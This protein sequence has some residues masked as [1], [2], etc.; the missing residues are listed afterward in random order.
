MKKIFILSLAFSLIF[1]SLGFAVE[2]SLEEKSSQLA[3]IIESIKNLINSL[4]NEQVAAVGGAG[5]TFTEKVNAELEVLV[6]GPGK[7][8]FYIYENN[9]NSLGG[10]FKPNANSWTSKLDF[11]GV[12]T[13]QSEWGDAR[14][15]GTLIAPQFMMQ[16]KHF[17]LAVGFK[18]RFADKNGVTVEREVVDFRDIP[19]SDIRITKLNLPLRPDRFK[20]YKVFDHDDFIAKT[21]FD[22]IPL[23]GE[24]PEGLS[25]NLRYLTV[26][27][28]RAVI[29][30]QAQKE[31]I[32]S[33]GLWQSMTA[34]CP[35]VMAPYVNRNFPHVRTYDSGGPSF[36]VYNNELVFVGT[37][38]TAM[39]CS[40]GAFVSNFINQINDAM[41]SMGGSKSIEKISLSSFPNI[42]H[43][44]EF[45]NVGDFSE[46][47]DLDENI[48]TGKVVAKLSAYDRDLGQSIK[49]IEGVGNGNDFF[50]V[51]P[52][53]EVV[54]KDGTKFDF[55]SK[56][57]RRAGG[58]PDNDLTSSPMFNLNVIVEDNGN[59]VR[60]HRLQ[61]ST[62]ANPTGL[63]FRVNNIDDGE[64]YNTKEAT[65]SLRLVSVNT[66]QIVG[67]VPFEISYEVKDWGVDRSFNVFLVKYD[68]S[69]NYV[70]AVKLGEIPIDQLTESKTAMVTVSKALTANRAVLGEG[71][72]YKIAI[73]AFGLPGT[74]KERLTDKASENLVSE[75]EGFLNLSLTPISVDGITPGEA[76]SSIQRSI[77]VITP[78][79]GSVLIPGRKIKVEWT[80][81]NIETTE[82]L[83]IRLRSVETGQEYNLLSDVLNDETE[84]VTVLN[85]IPIGFYTLEV[86]STQ[87]VIGSSEI[88]KV[89]R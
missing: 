32:T 56:V 9:A 62:G 39:F 44:P 57:F 24:N 36:I 14:K 15:V 52:N 13:W 83:T 26:N 46:I 61:L 65:K 85:S 60:S 84:R 35:L 74:L 4:K 25:K 7:G 78:A 80:T 31:P 20:I 53:G 77:A 75:T 11:T 81:K 54:V 42:N 72:N 50:D 55:E 10:A 33:S 64:S 29:L 67:G 18:V 45:T 21:H 30:H 73:V 47:I 48:S 71:A 38:S 79:R 27:Q 70:R 76:S 88:L 63:R 22:Y 2:Q 41:V 8:N 66:K 58:I 17:P 40:S 23:V 12:M 51:L 5:N 49:F 28:D 68:A 43:L 37:L 6:N 89:G 87:G 16:A 3:S 34:G 82:K 1:P 86:L 19:K 59:P 69:G